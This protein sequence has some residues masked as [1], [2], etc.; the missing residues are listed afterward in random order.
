[1]ATEKDTYS[2][3]FWSS[4]CRFSLHL[5]YILVVG[6]LRPKVVDFHLD[7]FSAAQGARWFSTDLG[8]S[9]C[10][11]LGCQRGAQDHAKP[12]YARV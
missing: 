4:K 1:M 3:Q 5:C 12:I 11:Y 7:T 2:V 10:G 9:K 6:T 8:L